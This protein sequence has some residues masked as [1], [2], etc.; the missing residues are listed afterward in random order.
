VSE[1]TVV[2]LGVHTPATAEAT[3]QAEE[4]IRPRPSY[5]PPSAEYEERRNKTLRQAE[6]YS[7][8]VRTMKVVLPLSAFAIVAASMLFVL[9]YDADDA[10]TVS[11]TSIERLDNDLRMVNPRFSGVDEERRPFLV[12][13]AA[14]VQDAADPRTVTLETIQADMNLS[15]LTWVS[16]QANEGVLDTEAEILQLE[17][18]ISVFS[19]SGYEFHTDRAQV[20]FDTRS[21]LS[22]SEVNAHGPLG[23]IR[24]DAFSAGNAGENIRFDGNVRMLIYPPGS[25]ASGN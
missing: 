14:A 12:T 20:R 16:V 9:L 25:S 10:L 13:A 3:P 22:D 4:I 1:E 5:V 23:T 19:D 7:H 15:E 2:S 8:F 21:V 18:D 11:F 17:G 6:R 24:A